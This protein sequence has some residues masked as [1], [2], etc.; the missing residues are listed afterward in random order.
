M[1]DTNKIE[2]VSD[3]SRLMSYTEHER[4]RKNKTIVI[5]IA[6]VLVIASLF[7]AYWNRSFNSY[8]E[9]SYTQEMEPVMR[10]FWMVI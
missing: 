6:V 10:S 8:K 7:L 3:G 2:I 9:L 5:A 4:I 1:E